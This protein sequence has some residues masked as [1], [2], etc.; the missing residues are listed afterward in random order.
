MQTLFLKVNN[1]LKKHVL[2]IVGRINPDV[3]LKYLV[4]TLNKRLMASTACPNR[5]L[6]SIKPYPSTQSHLDFNAYDQIRLLYQNY[7][8]KGWV[9]VRR[10]QLP[11]GMI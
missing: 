11:L 5:S 4:K 1:L 9:A 6:D 8:N 3:V 7:Y 2:L 10:T